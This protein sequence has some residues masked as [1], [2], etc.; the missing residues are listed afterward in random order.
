MSPPEN[1]DGLSSA[2]LRELVVMLLGKVTALKQVVVEQRSEI[3][4]LKGLKGPP[5]IKPSG[6]EGHRTGQAGL[7][8]EPSTTW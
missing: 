5:A 6:M 8:K 4:R 3:A 7:A 2:Q 1:L